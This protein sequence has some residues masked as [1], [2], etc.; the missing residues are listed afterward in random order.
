MDA[1]FC[2]NCFENGRKSLLQSRV[3]SGDRNVH[4]VCPHGCPELVFHYYLQ[5]PP[6]GAPVST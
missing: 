1:K 3:A 2:A 6:A 4:L 5:P